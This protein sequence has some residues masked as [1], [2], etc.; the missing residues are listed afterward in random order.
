MPS[1][2]PSALLIFFFSQYSSRTLTDLSDMR[3]EI[4]LGF[5]LDVGLPPLFFSD[6]K[7]T[8]SYVR[9]TI[10]GYV[11]ISVKEIFSNMEKIHKVGL[12]IALS[13]GGD[14]Y[15]SL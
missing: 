10:I 2:T 6:N 15:L 3:T 13:Y 12:G 4:L 1:L 5:G 7:I 11:D 14:S 8:S 9:K